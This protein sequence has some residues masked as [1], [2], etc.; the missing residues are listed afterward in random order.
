M[1]LAYRKEFKSAG[2]IGVDTMVQVVWL[3]D[4]DGG[5]HIIIASELRDGLSD[6]R[7]QEDHEPNPCWPTKPSPCRR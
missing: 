6:G 4:I 3:K 1:A 7:P 5:Q 2:Y